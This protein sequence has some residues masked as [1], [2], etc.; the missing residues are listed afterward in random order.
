MIIMTAK[1]ADL[2]T[3]Q[4]ADALSTDPKTLR[5]WLRDS[6]PRDEQPGK[7]GRWVL[8]GSKAAISAARKSFAA[9]Q[10][11]EAAKAADRAAKAQKDAEDALTEAEGTDEDADAEVT[12]TE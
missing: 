3:K 7:G 5:K 9:W 4:L 6:T 11:A 10:V 1:T 8:P 12:E 2:S